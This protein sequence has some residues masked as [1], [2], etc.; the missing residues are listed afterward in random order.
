MT[1]TSEEVL[2]TGLL[3]SDMEM[4]DKQFFE[5]TDMIEKPSVEVALNRFQSRTFDQRFLCQAGID[6]L[7]P[8]IFDQLRHHEQRLE[9]EK[10]SSELGLR[11]AMNSLRQNGQLRGCLLDGHRYDIG[12]PKEYYRTFR[13]FALEKKRKPEQN[14]S[15]S[16]A[17]PLV[18]HI[19]KV[20]T[21][22]SLEKTSIYSA[23]APGRLDVMGG[24]IKMI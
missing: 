23:S 8:T 15:I 19:D 9:Q 4:K 21:L 11:E 24:V 5:I 1:C 7:P 13:A 18:Q 20:R 6:I 10:V 12:N 14:C 22:L 2:E 3:Q 16:K 17:W